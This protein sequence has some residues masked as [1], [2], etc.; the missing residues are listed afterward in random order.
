M[1]FQREIN[2]RSFL[3]LAGAGLGAA[4]ATLAG[5]LPAGRKLPPI[6]AHGSREYPSLAL[7]YDDC[8]LIRLLQELDRMLAAR[9]EM[10][11]TFFPVGKA[12]LNI[13]GHD[14]DLWPRL[15]R[16]GHEIGY[17][18]FDH[19]APSLLTTKELVADFDY[20]MET[21]AQVVGQAP[22]VRFARPPFSDRSR[23]FLELCLERN[24]VVGLW[25]AD[26]SS[27]WG[28]D[29]ARGSREMSRV[30]NGD[31]V[32]LHIRTS[33][34][35]NTQTA[36]SLPAVAAKRRVTMSQLYAAARRPEDPRQ[37]F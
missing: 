21:A 7:T 9:P 22:A 4:A 16:A 32:L 34:I 35:T 13:A 17:H 11:V 26:W 30:R 6:F 15:Y 19:T 8:Y 20:W 14:P 33:D 28:G 37:F 29:P 24:L 23:S 31:V 27:E 36:L 12:L 1:P 18:T 5:R 10:R 3:K 2:R 25:S